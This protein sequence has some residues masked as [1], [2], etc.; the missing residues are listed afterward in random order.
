MSSPP[1]TL[2]F[3]VSEVR[4]ISADV[5]LVVRPF[6]QHLG[7]RLNTHA[8]LVGDLREREA[9]SAGFAERFPPDGGE[10]SDH[11]TGEG[12]EMLCSARTGERLEVS[13]F[14]DTFGQQGHQP[15]E[16]LLRALTG[17]IADLRSVIAHSRR[18][19]YSQVDRFK[20]SL[21]PR[22]LRSGAL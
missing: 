1:G 21:E 4:D 10:A 2:R 11:L 16:A 17:L 14:T 9:S 19:N 7:H 15:F 12:G 5:A 8:E 22:T 13:E 6:S 3:V 18:V 20:G